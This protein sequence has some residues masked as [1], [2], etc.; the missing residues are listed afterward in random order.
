MPLDIHFYSSKIAWLVNDLDKDVESVE[1]A[2]E[3]VM[4]SS[5]VVDYVFH[6]TGYVG[7]NFRSFGAR[8]LEY[9]ERVCINTPMPGI[10]LMQDECSAFRIYHKSLYPDHQNE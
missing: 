1:N 10:S 3:S 6:L 4:K 2:E 7:M 9:H 5:R 8:R